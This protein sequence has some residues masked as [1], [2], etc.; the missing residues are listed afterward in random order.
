M[1]WCKREGQ[2]HEEQ[3]EETRSREDEG[4][5]RK[6]TLVDQNLSRILMFSIL[7]LARTVI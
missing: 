6:L 3:R 1:L 5:R 7:I 2:G 4:G